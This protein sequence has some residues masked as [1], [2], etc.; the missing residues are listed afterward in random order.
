MDFGGCDLDAKCHSPSLSPTLGGQLGKGNGI[1]Y[2]LDHTSVGFLKRKKRTK[3]QI[4]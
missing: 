3:M 1:G 4:H 2:G